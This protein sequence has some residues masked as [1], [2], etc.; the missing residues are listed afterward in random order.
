MQWCMRVQWCWVQWCIR[1][2]LD[3]IAYRVD[4]AGDVDGHVEV[5]GLLW[6]KGAVL[7]LYVEHSHKA[8][9]GGGKISSAAVLRKL[10]LVHRSSMPPLGPRRGA[11]TV[12]GT[13]PQ[14]FMGGGV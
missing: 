12:C 11:R 14:R 3:A 10:Q 8:G 9:E 13:Q 7:G 1:V 4:E 5:V 6:V 2:L